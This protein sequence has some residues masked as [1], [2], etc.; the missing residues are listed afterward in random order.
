LAS[1]GSEEIGFV[2]EVVEEGTSIVEEL[3]KKVLEGSEVLEASDTIESAD[4][5]DS[6]AEEVD[7]TKKEVVS[8]GDEIGSV[9]VIAGEIAEKSEAE[10]VEAKEVVS[11]VEGVEEKPLDVPE[12]KEASAVVGTTEVL[13]TYS[14]LLSN[15]ERA[16]SILA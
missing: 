3:A 7:S 10:V 8:I 11:T 4:E 15:K 6:A 9:V 12:I 1:R 2:S 13:L 5:V 14:A 16:E